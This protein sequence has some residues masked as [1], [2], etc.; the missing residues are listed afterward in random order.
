MSDKFGKAVRLLVVG[1]PIKP[2]N[3]VNCLLEA[4]GGRFHGFI[5]TKKQ[6]SDT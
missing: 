6:P 1:K 3:T 2:L 5:C 4:K